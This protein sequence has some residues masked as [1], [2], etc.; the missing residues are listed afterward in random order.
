MCCVVLCCVGGDS[1]VL[2]CVAGGS[3]VLCYAGGRYRG[4]CHREVGR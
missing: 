1:A 3:A 2:S 4:P